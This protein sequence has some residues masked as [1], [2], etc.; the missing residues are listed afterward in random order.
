[1]N[2]FEYRIYYKWDGPSKC[3][4][5]ASEKSP[6]DVV[7]ALRTFPNE[8]SYRIEDRDAK[9]ETS[10]VREGTNEVHLRIRTTESLADVESALVA[11]LQDWRLYGER[12]DGPR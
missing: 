9:I 6:E 5:L 8:L 11:T 4:P 2:T 1:M 10:A 3:D 7:R 12:L